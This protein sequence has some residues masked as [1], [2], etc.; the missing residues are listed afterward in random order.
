MRSIAGHACAGLFIADL[1]QLLNS[2]DNWPGA[3]AQC[4]THSP[5]QVGVEGIMNVQRHERPV[6]PWRRSSKVSGSA[7]SAA[8]RCFGM[9]STDAVLSGGR[10]LRGPP[11]YNKWIGGS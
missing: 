11:D 5:R 6:H 7:A 8:G 2:A 9:A 4:W 1:I 3:V 10:L